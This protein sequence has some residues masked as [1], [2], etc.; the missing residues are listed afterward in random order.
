MFGGTATDTRWAS[1]GAVFA[2]RISF[3][4]SVATAV[5]FTSWASV[6]RLMSPLVRPPVTFV[7]VTPVGWTRTEAEDSYSLCWVM[8][9]AVAPANPRA[10]ASTATHQLLRRALR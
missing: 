4:A 10:A 2:L 9:N 8:V 7:S 3:P 6:S 5:D 1:C